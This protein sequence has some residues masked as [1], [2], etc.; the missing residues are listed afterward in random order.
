MSNVFEAIVCEIDFDRA[1]NLLAT[2]SSELTL[3]FIKINESLLVIYQLE[4]N[5]HRLIFS[6]QIEY[7][8]SQVSLEISAVLVMRYDSRIG[9][10]SSILFKEGLPI[11]SFDENDEIWVLLDEEGEPLIDGERFSINS[12]KDDEEYET[13]CNAIDLGLQALGIENWHEVYSFITSH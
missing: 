13:I 5:R 10:R 9:H 2:I 8:A 11:S 3:E 6:Q 4:E 1:K 7:L 12:M